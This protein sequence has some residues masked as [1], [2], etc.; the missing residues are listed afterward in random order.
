MSF[1]TTAEPIPAPSLAD[2]KRRKV[3]L[4]GTM[5]YCTETPE[6]AQKEHG[7]LSSIHA[8]AGY[9]CLGYGLNMYAQLGL[10]VPVSSVSKVVWLSIL[11]LH[12]LPSAV[13]PRKFRSLAAILW[14]PV[15]CCAGPNEPSHIGDAHEKTFWRS[16]GVRPSMV[17]ANQPCQVQ[18][19]FCC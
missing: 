5:Q 3:F 12:L 15:S 18:S 1:D 17:T 9:P 10:P 19:V 7:M 14:Q 16:L 6:M 4:P 2:S 11:P 8:Q 13:D